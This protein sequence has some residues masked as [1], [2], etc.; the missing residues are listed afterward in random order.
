[1]VA[2]NKEN[3]SFSW[4]LTIRDIREAWKEVEESVTFVFENY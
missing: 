3:H 2:G 4:I 1:M